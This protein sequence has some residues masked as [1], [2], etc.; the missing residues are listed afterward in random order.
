[1][2]V[3]VRKGICMSSQEMLGVASGEGGKMTLQRQKK[4]RFT[5]SVTQS[6]WHCSCHKEWGQTQDLGRQ[7]QEKDKVAIS[8]AGKEGTLT[9][10]Q[11]L[12]LPVPFLLV[13]F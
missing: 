3:L 12:C 9:G 13:C 8:G 1:M 5:L 10:I 6:D 11:Q 7:E 4:N 2:A